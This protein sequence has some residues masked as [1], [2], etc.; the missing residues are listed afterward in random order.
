[1]RFETCLRVSNDVIGKY[2]I[3]ND[4][5]VILSQL[6]GLLFYKCHIMSTFA[7]NMAAA[8]MQAVQC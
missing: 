4:L 5:F 7:H 6:D 1:M 8:Y 3:K 2:H